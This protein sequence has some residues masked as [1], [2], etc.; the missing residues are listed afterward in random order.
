MSLVASLHAVLRKRDVR[1]AIGWVGLIWL[2]PWIGAIVYAAFGL[3]RIKRRASQLHR[4]RRRLPLSTTAAMRI[5]RA[6][7]E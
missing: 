1:A 7:R 3:N 4:Q 6:K 2:A 5:A